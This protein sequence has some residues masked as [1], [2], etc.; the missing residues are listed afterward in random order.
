MDLTHLSD[1]KHTQD[2]ATKHI[3]WSE[4]NCQCNRTLLKEI[5]RYPGNIPSNTSVPN[6]AYMNVMVRVNSVRFQRVIDNE[7]RKAPVLLTALQRITWPVRLTRTE[8]QAP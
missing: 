1:G 3:S 4:I 6:W 8:T 7:F 2:L 5:S